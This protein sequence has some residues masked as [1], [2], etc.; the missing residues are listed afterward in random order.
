MSSSTTKEEIRTP[1][2]RLDFKSSEGRQTSLVGSTPTLFRHLPNKSAGR[3]GAGERL[4]GL[5]RLASDER[6]P[7]DLEAPR[8]LFPRGAAER[9]GRRADPD[10]DET[11]LCHH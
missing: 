1:V 6:I 7:V 3:P 2:G 10:V 11:D 9:I 8:V 5:I 4:S